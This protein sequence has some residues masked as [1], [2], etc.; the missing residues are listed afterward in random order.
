MKKKIKTLTATLTALAC[1]FSMT[2]TVFA[3]T[4]ETA[5]EKALALHELALL[6]NVSDASLDKEL[7]RGVGI[8]MVLK[9][10]GYT[11]ADADAA[12]KGN[13]HYFSPEEFTASWQIG[14]AYL[15][16]EQGITSGI[17]APVIEKGKVIQQG[18]FHPNA[19]M[20]KQMLLAFMLRGLGYEKSASYQDAGSL[21]LQ[22]GLTL[23]A[24]LHDEHFTKADAADI[25]Y[26]TLSATLQDE[27]EERKLLDRLVKNS[28]ID[29]AKLSDYGLEL[30]TDDI[31]KIESIH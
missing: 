8:A 9:A 31:F 1:A 2:C 21:A 28:V 16:Y 22:S 18:V 25:M 12:R 27:K 14:W 24:N 15:A 29:E 30:S 4:P 23:S 19:P 3:K 11:Q 26:N 6:S 10:L 13:M 7:D 20:N 5:K 17:S